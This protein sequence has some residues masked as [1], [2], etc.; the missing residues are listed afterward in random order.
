MIFD[1]RLE[2]GA[3]DDLHVNSHLATV[4]GD[5]EDTNGAATRLKGLLEPGPERGLV[6]DGKVLLD[7]TSLGHGDDGA[8]LHVEDAVLLEDGAEHGLDH[9][10]GGR[11]R[12][13][14]GLLMELLG[15]E[16]DT[17]VAV[18]A[19]GGG[20]RDADD[21]ARAALEDEDVA[22]ADVVARDGHGVG[23]SLGSDGSTASLRDLSNL[24]AMGIIVVVT[25]LVGFG[26]LGAGRDGRRSVTRGVDFLLD[27]LDLLVDLAMRQACVGDGGLAYAEMG[28]LVSGA[29]S[30]D[31]DGEIASDTRASLRG[32]AGRRWFD[33]VVVVVGNGFGGAGAVV[34]DVDGDFLAVIGLDAGAIVALSYVDVG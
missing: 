25:H 11:V 2:A 20:G 9:N 30:N 21:L 27:D 14:R 26:S 13:E 31:V 10:A 5:N 33:S 12:D 29:G 34:V 17:E 18:L 7:V 1:A 23:G 3:V 19:G 22:E 16:V 8:I 15:E 32:G 4:V 28:F 24:S 6:N